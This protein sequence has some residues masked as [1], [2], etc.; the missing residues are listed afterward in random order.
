MQIR[1]IRPDLE[2]VPVRGNILTRL[3]KL[4]AGQVQALI[5]A[6]AGL[7]RLGLGSK[8]AQVLDPRRFIPAPGQGA[9]AVQVRTDDVYAKGL[10]HTID[11][12]RVRILV[13]AERQVLIKT[14]C[15]CH[16]PIGAFAE[17][18][19]DSICIHAFIADPDGSRLASDKIKGHVDQSISLASE[20]AAELIARRI[21]K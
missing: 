18:A 13:E 19:K 20:L 6:R 10:I 11:Q 7:E 8:I 16:A 14:G 12:P 21:G 5:L 3:A 1:R 15:G 4:D 17:L 2:V 9:L